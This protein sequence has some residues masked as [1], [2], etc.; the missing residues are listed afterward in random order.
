MKLNA[1]SS[2]NF[3][4]DVSPVGLCVTDFT[5]VIGKSGDRKRTFLKAIQISFDHEALEPK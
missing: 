5:A 4:S 3:P 1:H 2:E